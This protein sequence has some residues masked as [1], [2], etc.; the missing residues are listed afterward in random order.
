MKKRMGMNCGHT[1]NESFISNP[2]TRKEIMLTVIPEVAKHALADPVELKMWTRR[3]TPLDPSL[4]QSTRR[5]AWQTPIESLCWLG[6]TMAFVQPSRYTGPRF[7]SAA[8]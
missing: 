6:S 4:L 2:N 7:I 3:R 5:V 8:E 1:S